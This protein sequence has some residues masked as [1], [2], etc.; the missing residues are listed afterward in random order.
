MSEEIRPEVISS[1]FDEN[2][3]LIPAL[4]D[5]VYFLFDAYGVF[6]DGSK[7][8]QATVEDMQRLVAL[9]KK[10]CVVSNT[11]ELSS[12]AQKKYKQRAINSGFLIPYTV[13]EMIELAKSKE[14]IKTKDETGKD[15]PIEDII[16]E[17]KVL[18]IIP[19]NITTFKEPIS[20]NN[21]LKA[22]DLKLIEYPTRRK[23]VELLI[24]KNKLPSLEKG[25]EEAKELRLIPQDTEVK[26]LD[27]PVNKDCL[28][29]IKEM[30]LMKDFF[31]EFITSGDVFREAVS[32]GSLQEQIE[33]QRVDKL[34]EKGKIKVYIFGNPRKELFKDSNFDIVNTP[35]EANCVYLSIPSLTKT[36]VI[37]AVLLNLG[38]SQ[39]ELKQWEGYIQ[40]VEKLENTAWKMSLERIFNDI[41][42]K[43]TKVQKGKLEQLKTYFQKSS[44]TKPGEPERWDVIEDHQEI[45]YPFLNE[46]MSSG[47]PILNANPDC[48]APEKNA[49]NPKQTHNVVRNGALTEYITK[50]GGTVFE[51]GKPNVEIFECALK[52]LDKEYKRKL[53]SLKALELRLKNIEQSQALSAPKQE[54][55]GK[56]ED[57][58]TEPEVLKQRT[59][60]LEQAKA[61]KEE[62]E[63]TQ[64]EIKKDVMDKTVMVG[65][66]PRTDGGIKKLGGTFICPSTGNGEKYAEEEGRGTNADY[67]LHRIA[68]VSTEVRT[69]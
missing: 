32:N 27:L 68:K 43:L 21:V 44:L 8:I 59:V 19:E 56:S 13:E 11:T 36:Q 6:W 54:E 22:A 5:K 39:E 14:T 51:Y 3:Q 28:E 53:E 12:A 2:G 38:L 18:G 30:N 23:I 4:R 31:G 26:N 60:L 15:K 69:R 37:K 46:F 25:I 35:K 33:G 52:L 7:L 65:D 63:K 41:G 40:L 62:A 45:F 9:G 24:C 20:L 34:K 58:F 61:A 64:T 55:G 16:R 49:E 47:L 29:E 48:S 50:E 10:V 67:F 57:K 1:I 66:T 42:S 17:A